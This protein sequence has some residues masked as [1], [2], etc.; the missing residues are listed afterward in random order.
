MQA[1]GIAIGLYSVQHCIF[2]ARGGSYL[3]SQEVAAVEIDGAFDCECCP[4]RR[5]GTT[6]C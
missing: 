5:V 3:G 4:G 6:G 1:V 2:W